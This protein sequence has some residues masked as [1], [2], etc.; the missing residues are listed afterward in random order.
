M[1]ND[2]FEQLRRTQ[3]MWH[4]MNSPLFQEIQ[5]QA[6]R[7]NEMRS[8]FLQIQEQLIAIKNLSLTSQ[9]D[10]ISL[11]TL[12]IQ[13]TMMESLSPAFNQL[14]ELSQ[15]STVQISQ[16][17]SSAFKI[18]F[19]KISP[20][21]KIAMEQKIRWDEVV[22]SERV[23]GMIN[24]WEPIIESASESIHLDEEVFLTENIPTTLS[25]LDINE[26]LPP[27]PD[28]PVI[29]FT[30]RD[31]LTVVGLL[32]ALVATLDAGNSRGTSLTEEIYGASK[33]SVIELGQILDDTYNFFTSN[34][35]E[36]P[37]DHLNYQ[38][39]PGNP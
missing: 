39:F 20:L 35:P 33:T 18:D 19:E 26:A 37:S 31:F 5:R 27:Q 12:G 9:I 6:A 36:G 17:L 3:D 8:P 10:T 29:T 1:K 14:R 22:P 24:R 7:I 23:S 28:Q 16:N 2:P 25:I 11:G 13:Q 4:K 34:F 21:L 32:I 38:G 30:W 15:N